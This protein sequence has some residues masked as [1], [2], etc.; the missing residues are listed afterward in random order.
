M[1][2][3]KNHALNRAGS[4]P[5]TRVLRI[6]RKPSEHMASLVLT[7]SEH[8]N[9]TAATPQHNVG[10]GG[11]EPVLPVLPLLVDVRAIRG[12]YNQHVGPRTRAVSFVVFVILAEPNQNWV[13]NQNQ[14][15]WILLT[16]PDTRLLALLKLNH[17]TQ[18]PT[19]L[20]PRDWTPSPPHPG[21]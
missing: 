18:P 17:R 20:S 3:W 15:P 7:Q 13:Q 8:R 19:P 14:Q 12:L 11:G 4:R 9:Q 16:T 10:D 21:N 6:T 2:V 5:G 1:K